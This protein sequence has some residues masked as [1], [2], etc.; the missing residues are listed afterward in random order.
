MDDTASNAV[1]QVQALDEAVVVSDP[2]GP[3]PQ[4]TMLGSD[5]AGPSSAS[6]AAGASS[7]SGTAFSVAG[8]SSAAAVAPMHQVLLSQL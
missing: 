2:P 3:P 5:L 1:S 8:A 6:A 7:A 4:A